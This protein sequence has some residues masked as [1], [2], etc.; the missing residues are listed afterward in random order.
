MKT[1]TM[2]IT[3]ECLTYYVIIKIKI[4]HTSMMCTKLWIHQIC[5]NPWWSWVDDDVWHAHTFG[6][7]N[8]TTNNGLEYIITTFCINTWKTIHIV[9][10]HR[11]HSYSSFI[12]FKKL[13]NI[14]EQSPK[15]CPINI[16]WD[17]NVD[18]LEDNNHA[19]KKHK[20]D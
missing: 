20:N 14:I 8:R 15:L 4:R 11:A 17:L 6:F 9:F 3:F 13:Q 5:F 18:I 16:L 1:S 10:V 2:T 12:V 7:F 19:K